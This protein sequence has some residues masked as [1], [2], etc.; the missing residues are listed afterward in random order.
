MSFQYFSPWSCMKQYI[1]RFAQQWEDF[2]LPELVAVSQIQQVNLEF[3]NK[4]YSNQV[5]S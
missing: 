1:C 4:D 3:D 5:L 2:R